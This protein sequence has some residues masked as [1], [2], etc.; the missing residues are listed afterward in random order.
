MTNLVVRLRTWP[1]GSKTMALLNEAADE[2]ERLRAAL[3]NIAAYEDVGSDEITK[4][5]G[6]MAALAL[7]GLPPDEPTDTRAVPMALFDQLA[8]AYTSTDAEGIIDMVLA[9]GA[10]WPA[11]L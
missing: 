4:H 5:L 2:I 6:R 9:S 1:N 11:A 8:K 3:N 10:K 7:K